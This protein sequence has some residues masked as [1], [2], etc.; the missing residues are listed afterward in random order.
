MRMRYNSVGTGHLLA[1][2][3]QAG[4]TSTERL[5]GKFDQPVMVGNR[6]V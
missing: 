2:M 6:A 4:F 5:D 3:G 1:L